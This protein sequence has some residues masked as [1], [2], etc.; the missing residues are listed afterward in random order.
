M[1]NRLES[2]PTEHPV[3][4]DGPGGPLLAFVTERDRLSPGFVVA[5]GAGRSGLTKSD[6]L[7]I[8]MARAMADTG[9][10][11]VRFDWRGTGSSLGKADFM[12]E[13]LYVDDV[14]AATSVFE[15]HRPL[16]LLGSC[17]GAR[18]VLRAAVE[19]EDT[20]AVA[21]LAYPMP[22]KANNR[23]LKAKRISVAQAAGLALKPSIIKG[24]FDP[25]MRRL[26]GR[27]LSNRLKMVQRNALRR[28]GAQETKSGMELDTLEDL[29]EMLSTLVERGVSIL[30]VFGEGE[31][32]LELFRSAAEQELAPVLAASH[33]QIEVITTSEGLYGWRTVGTIDRALDIAREWA[34]A[35][36]N[37]GRRRTEQDME[38][39]GSPSDA[40]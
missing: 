11:V 6:G 31:Q 35:V 27:W 1:N 14:V 38:V 20:I 28:L 7:F 39:S 16:A 25:R 32:H 37:Q 9:C 17:Y 33:G 29:A 5:A 13:P 40:S 36:I 3:W 24:W 21:L 8:R 19:L 2:R 12:N 4:L 34:E 15:Q 26:Y 18:S 10:D 22:G 30:F 23:E